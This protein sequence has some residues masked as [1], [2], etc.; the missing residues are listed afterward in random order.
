MAEQKIA[1]VTGSSSGIGLLTAVE[2]AANGYRVVATMRD[3]ARS[4]RLEEAAQK[5]GVRDRLDLRRLDVTE[6][7]TLP[8]AVEQIARDH[9]R[10]NVLVNN[11]GFSVAGFVEDLSLAEIRAQFE[12]NFFGAVAMSK[13]VLPV[14]R[15]QKSGHIIQISSVG[16]QVAYPLLGAYSASKWALEAISESLRIETQSLGIRVVLVEPGSYDTDIWTRNVAIAKAGLDDSSPNKE[17]SRRFSEFIK[18]R[19]KDRADA[20]D[21]ARLIVRIANDPNPRLRYLIGKATSV[22]V[23]MR[24]LVP[25]HRYERMIA[26]AVKID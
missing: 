23:W 17:R 6:F 9:G 19:G 13:A 7:E 4:G 12:T 25:W 3:L 18:S 1:V 14:M 15:R 24:R 8:T 21:V 11:A 16:G 5:A 20:R 22:Q 10:I 2:F 26:K